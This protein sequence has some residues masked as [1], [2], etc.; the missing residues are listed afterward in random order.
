MTNK[1]MVINIFKVEIVDIQK[2]GFLML[3]HPKS[4]NF[5]LLDSYTYIFDKVKLIVNKKGELVISSTTSTVIR[6]E[7]ED[8]FTVESLEFSQ[9]AENEA[10]D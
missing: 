10:Y 5:T 7:K 8:T 6:E 2:K 1:E 4:K 9:R 3:K